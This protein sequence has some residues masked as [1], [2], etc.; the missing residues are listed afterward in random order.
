MVDLARVY[1]SDKTLGTR[2]KQK[3]RDDA[4]KRSRT[5]VFKVHQAQRIHMEIHAALHRFRRSN[6]GF[7]PRVR[8]RFTAAPSN[9][10]VV[11]VLR[12]IAIDTGQNMCG[13]VDEVS[14]IKI[15]STQQMKMQ[16]LA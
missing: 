11:K 9:A 6:S 14:P 15:L 2:A 12:F 3:R 16:A 4:Q 5:T 1:F 13:V 8:P 10:V 7:P